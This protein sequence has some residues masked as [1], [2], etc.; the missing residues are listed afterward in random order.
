MLVQSN[1]FRSYDGSLALMLVLRGADFPVQIQV[2][3]TN[4]GPLQGG[5]KILVTQ[6]FHDVNHKSAG[7]MQKAGIEPETSGGSP[8]EWP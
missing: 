4:T 6:R 7:M 2:Q 3:R 1:D 8:V 5:Y